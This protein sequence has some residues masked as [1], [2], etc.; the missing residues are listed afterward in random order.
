MARVHGSHRVIGLE[1]VR[2]I[3][4]QRSPPQVLRRFCLVAAE[5]AGMPSMSLRD[6]PPAL[7]D[8]PLRP[9]DFGIRMCTGMGFRCHGN[10][11]KT[12]RE[13]YAKGNSNHSVN[14]YS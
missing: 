4:L 12:Q 10:K 9:R 14:S 8:Q 1:I 11:G 7:S 2:F 5:F 6:E 13:Q 3:E